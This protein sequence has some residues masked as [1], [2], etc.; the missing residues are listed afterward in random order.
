MAGI[1]NT[2]LFSS[3]EKLTPSSAGDILRMQVDATDSARINHTGNP[4]GV[5]SANPSSLCHD[6]TSGTV[7]VKQTGTSNTGWVAMPGISILV[8]H[9]FDLT[10]P[11]TI[12]L[13]T[14]ANK[15]LLI[16]GFAWSGVN[17]NTITGS[18]FMNFG[19]TAPDYNDYLDGMT[20]GLVNTTGEVYVAIPPPASPTIIVPPLTT[21]TAKIVTPTTAVSDVEKL[22]VLGFYL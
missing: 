14:T 9:D 17:V 2:T 5:V 18:G 22:S 8:S 20:A 15:P 19:W 6:T 1:D 3:G 16:M 13:F 12:P 10:V 21:F 11:A 4:E 7:Y